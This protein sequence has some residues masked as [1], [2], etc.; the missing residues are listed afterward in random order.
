MEKSINIISS[1]LSKAYC[2]LRPTFFK[3]YHAKNI[4]QGERKIIY[5]DKKSDFL[6]PFTAEK[7]QLI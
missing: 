5:K 6:I 2:L 3:S 7:I 4:L 1:K